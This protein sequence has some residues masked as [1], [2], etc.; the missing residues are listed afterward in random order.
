MAIGAGKGVM[1]IVGA[2][3][4]FHTN[5][6]LGLARGFRNA[7]KLYND[8]TVRP[9]EKVTGF[10]SGVKV[11]GK[12]FGLGFYDGLAGLVTQPMKGAEKEGGRGLLKGIGK[13]I[14]GLALK[15]AAGIWALPA[16]VS[17]G[18]TVEMRGLFKRAEGEYILASRVKQGEEDFYAGSTAEERRNILARWQA[19]DIREQ[20]KGFWSL[21]EKQK[22]PKKKEVDDGQGGVEERRGNIGASEEVERA[23]AGRPRWFRGR[24]GRGSVVGAT[25]TTSTAAMSAE[26]NIPLRPPAT[27]SSASSSYF[28]LDDDEALE[29][30]ILESVAQTSRGDREDDA[31]VEAAIRA[32]VRALRSATG[33]G[34]DSGQVAWEPDRKVLPQ[35][36]PEPHA[37]DGS[38]MHLGGV[39]HEDEDLKNI[40]D[41]EY[42][43]LIEEAVRRSLLEQQQEEEQEQWGEML[44]NPSAGLS[45]ISTTTATATTATAQP[46]FELPVDIPSAGPATIP[47][48]QG[49]ADDE[50][51]Q[52]RRAIEESEREHRSREENLQRQKT[53]EEIVLEYVMRQSLAEEEYRRAAWKGKGVARQEPGEQQQEPH[54]EDDE[55]LRRALEYS[56]MSGQGG[57]GPSRMR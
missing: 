43:A 47:P 55:E 20:L 17:Q 52:L 39:P 31:R 53:E 45:P 54:E 38:Q 7:P 50:E 6:C 21:K 33:P 8:D 18:I 2:G 26:A 51:E 27:A 14:A 46:V 11:A 32:S 48:T 24:S 35:M 36:I 13:G 1:R 30:A 15:P 16:Y 23:F 19:R 25:D 34:S 41:E 29:S 5:F 3:M 49:G 12:E 28:P 44:A 57:A 22:E 37:G 4:K 42:Q 9:T 10:A 40:T 56:K